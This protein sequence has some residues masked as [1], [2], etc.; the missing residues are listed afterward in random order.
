VSGLDHISSRSDFNL[1]L[2]GIFDFSNN[3]YHYFL[4]CSP[5][6]SKVLTFMFDLEA[7][8]DRPKC[9]HGDE[10]VKS[11]RAGPLGRKSP[12]SS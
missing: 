5:Q 3:V 6:K 2:N 12:L 9:H 7:L 11:V 4:Y 8:C 10:A 1:D